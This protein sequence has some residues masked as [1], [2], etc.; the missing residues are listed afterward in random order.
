M[1]KGPGIAFHA[2]EKN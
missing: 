1:L 2:D